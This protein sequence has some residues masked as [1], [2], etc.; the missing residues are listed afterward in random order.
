MTIELVAVGVFVG[1]ISGF[2]G[3]GGGMI[4]VPLLMLIGF[5]IKS[6]IAISTVQMVFSSVN[7]SLM[8]Y[9]KGKLQI[10]EGIWVGVGGLIGGVIGAQMTDLLPQQV[11]QYIFLGLIVFALF[12]L[13]TAQKPQ[14]GVEEGSFSEWILFLIGFGIGIIAMMLGVGGSVML[15]PILVGFLH[16]PTKKAATAGLFFVVFSS[17]SGLAYKL[18][19]GTFNDLSL[20]LSTVLSVAVAA[21]IGVMLGIL[22]KDVVHDRHHRLSMIVM[23]VVILGLMIKKIFF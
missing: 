23:Y 11:L 9:F 19:A 10:N 18:L 17:I 14:V 15:T 3:V 21:L 8:N 7:G 6:A 13:L 20:H 12:R 22:L 4:L 5:D 2:F 16:F 1:I